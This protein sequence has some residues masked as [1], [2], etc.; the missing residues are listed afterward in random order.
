MGLPSINIFIALIVC[1]VILIFWQICFWQIIALMKF[2][3]NC[4]TDQVHI[5]K[6]F[7]QFKLHTIDE[8]LQ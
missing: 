1:R 2:S 3:A 6:V 7:T 8:V 4:N 5:Y